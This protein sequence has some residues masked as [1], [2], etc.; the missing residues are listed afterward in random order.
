MHRPA[1]VTPTLVTLATHSSPL[2]S[3]PIRRKS[4]RLLKI[5]VMTLACL[6]EPGLAHKN[7]TTSHPRFNKINS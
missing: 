7:V 6:Q 2:T 1:S 4:E 5:G 3:E